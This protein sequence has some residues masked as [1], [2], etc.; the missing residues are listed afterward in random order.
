MLT[1]KEEVVLYRMKHSQFC[2]KVLL[3]KL[4]TQPGKGLINGLKS[5]VKVVV[6]AIVVHW[7]GKWT[8]GPSGINIFGLFIILL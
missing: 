6:Y 1:E 7:Q 5:V 2:G 8:Y 4:L 3:Q